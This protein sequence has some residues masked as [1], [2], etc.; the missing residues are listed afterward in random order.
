MRFRT[1]VRRLLLTLMCGGVAPGVAAQVRLDRADP[2]IVQQALPQPALPADSSSPIAPV[3]PS[4]SP[5]SGP[6]LRRVASAIVVDGNRQV[7][8]QAFA[9]A[10]IGYIGRELSGDDLS[11]LAGDVASVARAA[12]YPFASATIAPQTMS[13][14]ILRVT[15]DEGQ[16]AA[17]RVVGAVSPLADAIL[18]RAL[19]TG[20]AVRS[21]ALE[22]AI[23]RVGDI[24]GLSVRNSKYVR[25]DGFGILLVDVVEDRA[26]A[27]VQ[28]DN[29][30][31]AE[32]GPI[33]S[34]MLASLRGV[35]QSGDELGIVVA[36]TPLQPGEF[37]FLRARYT[38]PVSAAGDV[39]TFSGS[40]GRANPGASLASLN[41]VGNSLDAA[42][43]YARPILRSRRRSLS[44]NVELRTLRSDQSLLRSEL[45]D[46]R[47]TTLTGS[48]TAS[49]TLG[50]GTLRGEVAAIWGL[51]LAGMSRAGDRLTSRADGDARFGL[52]N[53]V[54]DWSIELGGPLAVVLASS[55][56]L[57]SRPLLATMEIGAGGPAFGRAYDYAERTGDQGVLGSAELRA[58]LGAIA[59]VVARTQFYTFVDGG[60]VDNL[61]GG[62]GGGSLL[63]TGTGVRLGRGKLDGMFE[64]ALP[65]NADRFDTGTKRPRVSFRVSRVF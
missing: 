3:L 61:R 41:V 37:A 14:G 15:L 30:G 33:R 25:Q 62:F 21:D 19:V 7:R 8:T 59:D 5:Q 57:A 4:A 32:V 35:A 54:I 18:S 39:L 47:L 2:S 55:G 17:V 9:P 48:L 64:V 24:P 49:A 50:V 53:Y 11:R 20:S 46:D 43:A 56:Q 44:T 27:Y 6:G 42:V 16:I 10:L 28:V 60:Y 65:L 38:S 13:G 45:R 36:L 40:Y 52:V 1:P 58:N 29:R 51:P 12:G 31:S 23:L 34:T 63:S 22:G 26:S